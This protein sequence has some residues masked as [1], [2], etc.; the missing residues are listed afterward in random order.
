MDGWMGCLYCESVTQ[1]MAAALSH[2][3]G[4]RGEHRPWS[5]EK[6]DLGSG[7]LRVMQMETYNNA[8]GDGLE[9]STSWLVWGLSQGSP[10]TA[11]RNQNRRLFA[12][13]A[14]LLWL[15]SA[16]RPPSEASLC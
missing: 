6:Q 13:S 16:Q 7:C 10:G 4:Q 8:P 2:L 9:E 12:P 14:H 3:G 5:Q 11:D 1:S 15:H